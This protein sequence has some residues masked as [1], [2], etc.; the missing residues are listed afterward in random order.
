L[1]LTKLPIVRSDKAS[2]AC[3]LHVSVEHRGSDTAREQQN[4]SKQNQSHC[5]LS[6]ENSYTGRSYIELGPPR[7]KVGNNRLS[8]GMVRV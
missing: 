3:E 2:V 7:S 8:H 4:Y 5:Y 6:H 1:Y